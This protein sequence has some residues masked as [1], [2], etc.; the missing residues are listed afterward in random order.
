MEIERWEDDKRAWMLLSPSQGRLD[1]STTWQKISVSAN[2]G[3][4]KGAE[5]MCRGKADKF[6]QE[7][8]REE[9]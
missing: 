1:D 3:G 8:E 7:R 9:R 6:T 2:E 4:K 5:G